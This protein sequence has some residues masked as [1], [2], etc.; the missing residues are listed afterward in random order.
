MR[1]FFANGLE[2]MHI[3]WAVEGLPTL[4]HLSLFL[5]FGGV[6]IF[7]FNIDHEVFIFVV[8]WIG[9]FSMVY[10]LITLLPIIRHDSPYNSPLSTPAWFLHTSI[11]HLTFKILA[12]IPC[13]RFWGYYAWNRSRVLRDRYQRW[14]LGGVEKAAEESAA[15]RSGYIDIQILDW[16]IGALGDDDSLKGFYEAIPGFFSSKLVA[17]HR[18]RDVPVE[19]FQNFRAALDGF[20]GRTWS[21]NSVGDSEKLRR[22]D[23]SMNAMDQIGDVWFFLHNIY[24]EHWDGMPQIVEMGHILARWCTSSEPDVAEIT[25]VI[26]ARILVNVRKRDD[27]WIA[28]AAR[29]SGLP[30]H[31]LRDNIAGCIDSVLLAILIQVIRPNIHSAG[32]S[33]CVLKTLSKL[34]IRNTLPRLQHDFC[35]LWNEIVQEPREKGPYTI[36]VTILKGIHHLYIAL[37]QGTDAAPTA[38]SDEILYKP[39][40]YPFCN[41]ASH[42]PDSVSQ[43]PVPKSREIPLP[44]PP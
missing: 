41:L 33:S 30:E 4:L 25:Q 26:I 32:V 8:W 42:R 11:H 19:V 15:E 23:L 6:V 28:L 9:L 22:F 14:M 12:F 31:D 34:D 40:L 44:A 20:L 10:G 24:F 29:V 38:S 1:A 13:G 5:F 2:K 17:K 7:L 21:F 18:V 36:P 3:P 27:S 43:F 39:S 35:T 16:T 37:H